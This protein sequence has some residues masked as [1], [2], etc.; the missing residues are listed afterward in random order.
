MLASGTGK[1][2]G[3]KTGGLQAL[4][5]WRTVILATGEEPITTETS[6]TGVSTRVLEIYGPPFDDEQSAGMMHQK[7]SENFGWAGIE[8]VKRV[9]SLGE[10]EIKRRF[11]SMLEFVYEKNS[12][13]N[14]SHATGIAAVATA[15]ALVDEWFFGAGQQE[16]EERAK[17][18]AAVIVKENNENSVRDVNETA[19]QYISDWI[20]SNAKAFTGDGYGQRLGEIE[21]QTAY[22]FPSLLNKAISDGGFSTRKTLKYLSE[23][24]IIEAFNE[25][26]S[27]RYSV[28]RRFQG[29][30]SRFVKVDLTRIEQTKDER[31]RP[32]SDEGV[33]TNYAFDGFTEVDDDEDLPF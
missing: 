25:N 29:G 16:A 6:Q 10:D 17:Q 2:R 30:K 19:T 32:H 4:Q 7:S 27:V 22:V 18:M 24:G 26:G 5:T 13:K 12:G 11:G 9:V 15:D 21:G 14:G 23:Q 31:K 20:S 3:S 1:I 33:P 8:F 28:Q